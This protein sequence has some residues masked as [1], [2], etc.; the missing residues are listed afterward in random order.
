MII[1]ENNFYQS[2]IVTQLLQ[3][4]QFQLLIKHPWI[5]ASMGF[6][7]FVADHGCVSSPPNMVIHMALD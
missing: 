6:P 1:A 5:V 2:I 4:L 3:S 7:T